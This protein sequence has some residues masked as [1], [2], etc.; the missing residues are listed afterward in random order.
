MS[1]EIAKRIAKLAGLAEAITK[2][3]VVAVMLELADCPSWTEPIGEGRCAL[4]GLGTP[5]AREAV[6]EALRAGETELPSTV[7][8]LEYRRVA[9]QF[10][11]DAVDG[12]DDSEL[13]CASPRGEGK[14]QAALGAM[15][16]HALVHQARGFPWPVRWLTVGPS[17]VYL[18]DTAGRSMR[19]A[20]WL[21]AWVLSADDRKATLTL[22]GAVLVEGDFVGLPTEQDADMLKREVHCVWTDEPAAALTEQAAGITRKAWGVAFS[23]ARL[24]THRRVGLLTSN[25]P[26][27]RSWVWRR[28]VLAPEPGCRAYRIPKG[29]RTT[30]EYRA[31]LARQ[32]ADSPDLLQRLGEGEAA[33]SLRGVPVARGYSDQLCVAPR[34]LEPLVGVPFYVGVDAGLSPACVVAQGRDGRCFVY[35]STTLDRGG[36]EELVELFLRPWLVEHAPWALRQSKALIFCCDP[37]MRT[38]SQ[39]ALSD[40]PELTLLKLLPTGRVRLGPTRWGARRDALTACFAPGRSRLWIS[41]VPENEDLRFGL[42]GAFH[43]RAT[44]GGEATGLEPVKDEA[45]HVCDA[46]IYVLCELWPA[47][48]REARRERRRRHPPEPSKHDFDAFNPFAHGARTR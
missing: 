36:T 17:V 48:D 27:P 40:S 22:D 1:R 28:F 45:S 19:A 23:S 15:L 16:C 31:D 47:E 8:H 18:G 44:S 37:N 32:L 42:G 10:I 9:S 3:Q 6:L 14:T 2:R 26:T 43:Y 12:R 39:H 5:A 33:L 30:E 35:A 21:G 38:P 20:H 4:V 7:L 34:V 24:V 25:A 11:A 46:L 13:L 29:E 41:P